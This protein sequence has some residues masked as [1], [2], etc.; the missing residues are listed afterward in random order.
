M[1]RVLVCLLA[2]SMILS[3]TGCKHEHSFGEWEVVEE[4]TCLESGKQERKCSCGETET[5]TIPATGHSFGEWEVVTLP[6][7]SEEGLQ[8]RVCACGEA[9]E[10]AIPMLERQV[11]EVGD[12][13]E[14]DMVR[15]TINQFCFADLLSLDNNNTWLHPSYGH[16]GYAPG[17]GKVFAWLSFDVE[18]TSTQ[19]LSYTDVCRMVVVYNEDYVFDDVVFACGSIHNSSSASYI[20]SGG[21]AILDLFDT[22]NYFGFAK[23][24]DVVK[25]DLESPLYAIL[26]FPSTTGDVEIQV[27]YSRDESADTSE[28]ARQISDILNDAMDDLEFVKKYAGNVN[29]N[30]SR[31]FADS[32]IQRMRSYVTDI[33][34]DYVNGHLPASAAALPDILQNIT[35]ICDMLEEMGVTNSD[36]DVPTMKSM[37]DSTMKDIQAL[38]GE[39]YS[40]FN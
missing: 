32:F 1:K 23:C 14:T 4:A 34:M 20:S 16:G 6:G 28:E 22:E 9:E 21:M 36:K 30:G 5:E 15:V 12:T 35:A 39:D 31:K 13:F 11:Y 27:N 33:N 26:T 7:Y 29:N 38:L 3:L 40:A 2:A 24:A 17:E 19:K 37:A 10:E 8:R 18:N 25:Y